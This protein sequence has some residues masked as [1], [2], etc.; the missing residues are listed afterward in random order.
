MKILRSLSVPN[1][2]FFHLFLT[3]DNFLKLK[4]GDKKKRANKKTNQ[5]TS[6]EQKNPLSPFLNFA[7]NLLLLQCVSKTENS[8][9]FLQ[10]SY[11]SV[12]LTFFRTNPSRLFLLKFFLL[13]Y[14]SANS[15]RILVWGSLVSGFFFL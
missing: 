10:K 2:C 14:I 1:C 9:L 5:T 6:V 13:G 12:C 15:F 8:G 3:N 7:V 11:F 4:R